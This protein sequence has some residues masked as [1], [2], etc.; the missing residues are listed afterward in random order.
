M[1]NQMKQATLE[2]RRT[3]DRIQ[4]TYDMETRELVMKVTR[5]GLKGRQMIDRSKDVSIFMFSDLIRRLMKTF[6]KDM[7]LVEE[8]PIRVGVFN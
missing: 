4:I 2:N 7:V 1:N 3:G 6:P 8:T 5:K